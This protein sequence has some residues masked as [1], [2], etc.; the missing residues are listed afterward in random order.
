MPWPLVV[1]TSF[2]LQDSGLFCGK[3][4]SSGDAYRICML[5]PHGTGV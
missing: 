2:S 5:V 4:D 1:L 3:L